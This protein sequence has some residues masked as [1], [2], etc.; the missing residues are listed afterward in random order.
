MRPERV[1]EI[2]GQIVASLSDGAVGPL[3]CFS[4]SSTTV[5]EASI[6]LACPGPYECGGQAAFTCTLAFICGNG[7]EPFTC[8]PPNAF[9]W[10][11]CTPNF[12][13][14][15]PTSMFEWVIQF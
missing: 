7:G 10:A 11:D 15:Q 6:N 5:Y 14:D 3:C 13:C 9:V 2:A 8:P 1:D 4:I 12:T